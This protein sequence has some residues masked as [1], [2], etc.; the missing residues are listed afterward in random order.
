MNFTDVTDS[1]SGTLVR[2]VGVG[3]RTSVTAMAIVG[4][5][6]APCFRSPDVRFRLGLRLGC[7]ETVRVGVRARTDTGAGADLMSL[8]VRI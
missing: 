7:I 5:R 4:A 6:T 8:D 3:V 2:A 1:V